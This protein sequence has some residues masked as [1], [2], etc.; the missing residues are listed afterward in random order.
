MSG[1]GIVIEQKGPTGWAVIG[2]G[3]LI[4]LALVIIALALFNLSTWAGWALIIYASGQSVAC[5]CVGVSRI[6]E[7]R[8]VALGRARGRVLPPRQPLPAAALEDIKALWGEG[9]V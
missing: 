8:G 9:D 2:A 4:G 7:A 6:V 3:G 5:V 1:Q